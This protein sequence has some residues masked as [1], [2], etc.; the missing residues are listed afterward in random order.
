MF[1][2]LYKVWAV[3]YSHRI[4]NSLFIKLSNL[5]DLRLVKSNPIVVVSLIV[6]SFLVFFELWVT[7]CKYFLGYF[8][9]AHVQNIHGG[10]TFLHL[11]C[12]SKIDK[13]V[14]INQTNA[15]EFSWKHSFNTVF[16]PDILI[17]HKNSKTDFGNLKRNTA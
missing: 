4:L 8:R 2:I 1:K 17:H 3:A 6:R 16:T 12:I 14:I 10:G 15:I 13:H 9:K 5:H 11:V 7:T